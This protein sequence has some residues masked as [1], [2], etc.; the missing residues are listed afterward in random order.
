M[1]AR[2]THG[3]GTI[4][5]RN[6]VYHGQW[7]VG[8]KQVMRRLGRVRQPGSS[9]GLTKTMAETRLREVMAE[10]GG[11]TLSERVSVTETGERPLA[12]LEAMGR[13]P[14]T[15]RSYRSLF[16]TQIEPRLGERPI[17][18]LS[19]E[20]IEQFFTGCLRD[21]L[22]PKTVSNA[23]GL[24]HSILEFAIT[25]GWATENPCK[26]V[27]RPKADEDTDIHFLDQDEVEALL[28][29]V[30][31]TDFGRIQRV[32]YITAVMTGMRQGELL[33]LRWRM[34]TGQPGGSACG[35][36]TCA[37]SSAPRSHGVA[38]GRS[39]WPTGSV[40]NWIA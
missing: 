2:R 31:V 9:D 19:R 23:L 35:A 32:I 12:H 7:R 27:E 16:H 40:A 36:T 29:A 17:A 10:H 8:G 20:D 34:S 24:L 18:R 38:R 28:R 14:S 26:R 6:G 5:E 13:K 30:P 15:M 37:V 22:Q 33:A 3:T 39:L 11:A 4:R 25:H 21:G 1:A